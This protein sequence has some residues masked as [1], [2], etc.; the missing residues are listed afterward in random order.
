MY[1]T[2][3]NYEFDEKE[4]IDCS[5]D[6]PLTIPDQAYTIKQLYDMR[7]RGCAPDCDNPNLSADYDD[8]TDI[9]DLSDEQFNDPDNI[10]DLQEELEEITSRQRFFKRKKK[11][12]KNKDKPEEELEEEQLSL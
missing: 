9:N 11:S 3:I 6:Q 1:I 5:Q 7:L 12:K 10:L 4:V 8:D 2:R